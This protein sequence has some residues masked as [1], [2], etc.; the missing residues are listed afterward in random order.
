MTAIEWA[1]VVF[2]VLAL[3]GIVGAVLRWEY[4]NR[5]AP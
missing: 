2:I 3:G 1:A 5:D 4:S